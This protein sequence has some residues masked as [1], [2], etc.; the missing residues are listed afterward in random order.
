MNTAHSHYMIHSFASKFKRFYNFYGIQMYRLRDI[1]KD[2]LAGAPAVKW[3]LSL[4][5]DFWASRSAFV[6][7]FGLRFGG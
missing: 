1:T 2:D 6:I 3:R 5:S 7:P 4:S